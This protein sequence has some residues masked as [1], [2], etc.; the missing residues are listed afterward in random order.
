[1]LRNF[2]LIT[3]ISSYHGDSLNLGEKTTLRDLD[4]K[5]IQLLR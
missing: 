4:D 5:K 3:E 1:M 2:P